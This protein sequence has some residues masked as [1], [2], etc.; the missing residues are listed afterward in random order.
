MTSLVDSSFSLR[1]H[2][3]DEGYTF[4]Y[5]SETRVSEL[6]GDE[7]D[8]YIYSGTTNLTEVEYTLAF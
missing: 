7:I 8:N 1:T 5:E 2:I 4:F 6:E 3:E